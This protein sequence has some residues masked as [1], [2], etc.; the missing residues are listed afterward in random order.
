MNGR[1]IREKELKFE[2][3]ESIKNE[4]FTKN[5]YENLDLMIKNLLCKFNLKNLNR[6]EV[7]NILLKDIEKELYKFDGN[8]AFGFFNHILKQRL[9]Q[10]YDS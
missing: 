2:I 9:Y 4:K 6:D 10:L 5:L 7:K 3:L 8:S 1:Y